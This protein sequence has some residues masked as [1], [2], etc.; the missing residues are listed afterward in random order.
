[1]ALLDDLELVFIVDEADAEVLDG[2]AIKALKKVERR[3]GEVGLSGDC[4]RG[5][6]FPTENIGLT[7]LFRS[8]GCSFR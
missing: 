2:L 3:G 7:E 6:V 8:F 4:G 5:D 1:M